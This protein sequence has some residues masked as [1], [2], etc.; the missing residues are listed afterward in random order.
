MG[1]EPRTHHPRKE[2]IRL[3]G[4]PD[5]IFYQDYSKDYYRTRKREGLPSRRP[6]HPLLLRPPPSYPAEY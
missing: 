1:K 3:L 5:L 2:L 4:V 6:S